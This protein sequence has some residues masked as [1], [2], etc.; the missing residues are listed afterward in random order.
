MRTKD[1]TPDVVFSNEDKTELFEIE[2]DKEIK[3]KKWR[4]FSLFSKMENG[5]LNI[6]THEEYLPHFRE[7]LKANHINN[8]KLI[9]F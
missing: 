9:Y 2:L 8:A 5:N 3:L 7:I 4:L 6:V 1:F